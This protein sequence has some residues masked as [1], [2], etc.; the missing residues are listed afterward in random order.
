MGIEKNEGLPQ[1]LCTYQ[2]RSRC[3]FINRRGGR[4]GTGRGGCS[5][6]YGSCCISDTD[7]VNPLLHFRAMGS[8]CRNRYSSP[9]KRSLPGLTQQ[10]G[11]LDPSRKH[12]RP[13]P[14]L[15][16]YISLIDH[17]LAL[18]NIFCDPE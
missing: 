8:K 5:S 11:G 10:A 6:S 16:H 15:D 14:S 3:C 7:G 17:P 4:G 13:A 18:K 9:K 1:V 12:A 2:P